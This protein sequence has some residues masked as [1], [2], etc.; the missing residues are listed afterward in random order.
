MTTLAPAAAVMMLAEAVTLQSV[1]VRAGEYVTA[2]QQQLSGIV[3]E[4]FYVQ[5]ATNGA[6]TPL[7]LRTSEHRELRSDLLLVKPPGVKDW[8]QFRD[9]FE[10]NGMP[11][12]GR[13]E[14]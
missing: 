4:E 1:L 11:I 12:R 8:V 14:R 3:A 5:G 10:V 2:F 9:V 13:D 6:L 7:V